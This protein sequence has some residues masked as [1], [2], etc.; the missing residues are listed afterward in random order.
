M[1]CVTT[2]LWIIQVEATK[3]VIISMIKDVKDVFQTQQKME[4]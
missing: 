2:H 4:M 1:N 3:I